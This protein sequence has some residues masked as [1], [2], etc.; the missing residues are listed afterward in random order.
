MG[1]YDVLK[2]DFICHTCK[3]I[4]YSVRWYYQD[5]IMTWMCKD[6]HVSTVDLNL[7]K[8]KV[9]HDREIGE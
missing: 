5:L 3:D 6:K 1:K 8:K 4:V 9:Y 2:G 7:K